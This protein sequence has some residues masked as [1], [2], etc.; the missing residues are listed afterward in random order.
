MSLVTEEGSPYLDDDEAGTGIIGSLEVNTLLVVRDVETL[1]AVGA[2]GQRASAGQAGK[3]GGDGEGVEL[4]FLTFFELLSDETI[5]LLLMRNR[6]RC[7]SY[8]LSTR[9]GH[10]R[11]IQQ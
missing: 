11:G 7:P 8:M 10:G 1:D 4:H 2:S 3:R 6:A 5:V 9:A